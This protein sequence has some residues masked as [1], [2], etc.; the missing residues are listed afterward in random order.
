[1]ETR[2]G[3]V[4]SDQF[5][6]HFVTIT[7]VGWVDLFTRKEC[8]E[9]LIE[10]LKFCVMKK[11]LIVYSYVIMPSHLHLILRAKEGS[12]GLSAIIR[13]FKKFTS[14]NLIKCTLD[15]PFESRKD[16]LKV[17]FEYHAKFNS[18]NQQF[19]LW[20][21]GNHPKILLHPK[22]TV[23]KLNYIHANPVVAGIVDLGEEYIY[24][25]ARNYIGRKDFVLDVEIIDFGAQIG[26]IPM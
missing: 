22:F 24:S 4:I 25:S 5:A 26:Y 1:M 10:S 9:I 14:R 20:Q 17:V 13:D 21:Q 2:R 8:K 3:Y 15:N 16:W 6:M 7:I 12:D 18:N 19:Q 11:G 23:Q